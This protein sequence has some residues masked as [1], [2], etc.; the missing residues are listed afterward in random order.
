MV[1]YIHFIIIHK[2]GAVLSQLFYVGKE[3]DVVLDLSSSM[4][5]NRKKCLKIKRY[6]EFI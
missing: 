1:A 3:E 6:Y 4:G 5:V 2:Y